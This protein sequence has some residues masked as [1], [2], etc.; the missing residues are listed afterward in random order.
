LNTPE[1]SEVAADA[2]IAFES[3]TLAATLGRV[4]QMEDA[5]RECYRQSARLRV[6][7]NYSWDAVTTSYEQLLLRILRR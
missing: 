7:D 1:N 4:L 2:G 6:E 5:E 3:G